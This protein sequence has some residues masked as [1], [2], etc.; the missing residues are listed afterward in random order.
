MSVVVHAVL[1]GMLIGIA[2]TPPTT[3][4]GD[5]ATV[6]ARVS[7]PHDDAPPTAT[8][9]V[10]ESPDDELEPI[11]EPDLTPLLRPDREPEHDDPSWLEPTDGESLPVIET[12]NDPSVPWDAFRQRVRRRTKPA[13]SDSRPRAADTEPERTVARG[14]RL[15][16]RP[17]L[18]RFYPKEAQ[19]MGIE[20]TTYLRI[21]I[22][23]R[24]RVLE[25]TVRR[26]SGH[27]AL[28]DAALRAVMLHFFEPGT[29]GLA[30][31]PITFRL[32]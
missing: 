17:D 24:G 25:A 5:A 12:M 28:D 23:E 16:R 21:L 9:L 26:S 6:T 32:R 3:D 19:R 1:I 10:V 18:S 31:L 15:R 11:D 2:H 8:E 14:A 22:S 30:I 4:E 27:P 20:G 7:T 29:P 13:A